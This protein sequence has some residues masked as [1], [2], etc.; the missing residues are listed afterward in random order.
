MSTSNH[1]D[2]YL[3]IFWAVLALLSHVFSNNSMMSLSTRCVRI[4]G[5]IFSLLSACGLIPN[6]LKYSWKRGVHYK[7][8]YL[9]LDGH[10]YLD[11]SSLFKFKHLGFL[12]VFWSELSMLYQTPKTH[13]TKWTYGSLRVHTMNDV[14]G[15]RCKRPLQTSYLLIA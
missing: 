12:L 15:Y 8:L 6:Y 14:L 3:W 10:V 9:V 13:P 7:S 4:G 1:N 2:K 11:F 5:M